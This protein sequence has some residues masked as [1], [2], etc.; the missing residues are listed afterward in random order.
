MD[1]RIS[2]TNY[3]SYK[4]YLE[5]VE[6]IAKIENVPLKVVGYINNETFLEVYSGEEQSSLKL[7]LWIIN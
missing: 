2:R 5:I 3:Y 1:S 7:S 6:N 4:T